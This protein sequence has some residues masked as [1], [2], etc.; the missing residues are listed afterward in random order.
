M[1]NTIYRYAL[2]ALLVVGSAT[3]LFSCGETTTTVEYDLETLMTERSENRTIE[4]T[5][6]GKRSYSFTAP[7]IEGYSLAKNPYQEFREGIKMTTY[8]SDTLSLVDATITANYAIYYDK[9]KLWEAKGNVVII[10]KNRKAGD[11]TVTGLTEVYTQQLFWDARTKK[12][13]SNVDTKILQPDGWHFGVGFEADEDLKNIHFRKYKSEMEFD[14]SPVEEGAEDD[15]KRADAKGNDG[16]GGK[17][18]GK[19]GERPRPGGRPTPRDSKGS[20]RG[21]TINPSLSANPTPGSKPANGSSTPTSKPQQRPQ[22]DAQSSMST[23]VDLDGSR[24]AP[25]SS[26][27]P[28][29]GSSSLQPPGPQGGA[30]AAKGTS[31]KSGTQPAKRDAQTPTKR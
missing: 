17:S 10:K 18:Q 20:Q 15:D 6:N 1:R 4:M 26:R 24:V 19:D 3:L 7:I 21:G 23:S 25:S 30:P 5:E 13:Y 29:K 2:L 11:T 31:P 28:G 8:T 16:K 14:F 22:L 27:G 9:Q 12:I